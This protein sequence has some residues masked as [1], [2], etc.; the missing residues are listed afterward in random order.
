MNMKNLCQYFTFLPSRWIKSYYLEILVILKI[1][2]ILKVIVPCS[3]GIAGDNKTRTRFPTGRCLHLHFVHTFQFFLVAKRLLE[4]D[5]AQLNILN[6]YNYSDT[7]F[8]SLMLNGRHPNLARIVL[9]YF[10]VVQLKSG[11]LF[12]HFVTSWSSS[13]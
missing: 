11:S 7:L 2:Q 12:W 8:E 1:R 10:P 5:A 6:A 3:F 4:K 13:R 9:I